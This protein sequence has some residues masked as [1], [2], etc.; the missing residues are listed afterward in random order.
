MEELF[1][2]GFASYE[3][4]YKRKDGDR[5]EVEC[6]LSMINDE[7]GNSIAGVSIVR[8]IS[9]RKKMQQQLIQSEKFKSLG[10]L[11]GGVAHDFN[12]VLAAI[13]GRAQLLKCDLNH[14]LVSR[15]KE[16]Q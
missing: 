11:A 4:K 7:E 6:Y 16:R 12:N 8:D 15:K 14:L 10:E 3:T 5:V 9:E 13:L 2:G 1:E